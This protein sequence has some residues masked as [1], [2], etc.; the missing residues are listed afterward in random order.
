M[1]ME[2]PFL[3]VLVLLLSFQYLILLNAV[4]VAGTRNLMF[5][6]DVYQVSKKTHSENPKQSLMEERASTKIE[7]ELHDYSGP[8][9]NP[10]HTPP[11]RAVL[12]KA[13]AGSAGC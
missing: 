8:G 7:V 11:P 5:D 12:A 13:C 2:V 4:P 6:S 9:A 3:N 1:A 10:K